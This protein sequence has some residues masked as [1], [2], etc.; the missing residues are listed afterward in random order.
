LR[1]RLYAATCFAGSGHN[2]LNVNDFAGSGHNK[3]IVSGF[4]GS[5]HNA[6]SY[7]PASQ[8]PSND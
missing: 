2:K 6:Y 8:V 7:L 3:L 1:P 5:G 4:A